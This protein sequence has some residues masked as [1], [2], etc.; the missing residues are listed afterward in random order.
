MES[1]S[2]NP[3]SLAKFVFANTA[4]KGRQKQEYSRL[5]KLQ[6]KLAHERNVEVDRWFHSFQKE[7][8]NWANESIGECSNWKPIFEDQAGEYRESYEASRLRLLGGD[9]HPEG[10]SFQCKPD[11]VME[12]ENSD[13]LVIERKWSRKEDRLI[14]EW[15]WENN[16]TQA[17][18]YRWIDEWGDLEDEKVFLVLEYY[19][20]E[21]YCKENEVF[22]PRL[23]RRV[24]LSEYFRPLDKISRDWLKEF[25]GYFEHF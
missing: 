21:Y 5:T 7:T 20:T 11:L 2:A 12:S 19:D 16:R 3:S 22:K 13:I 23:V 10:E 1:R 15:G 4:G 9:S 17:W 14:P 24:S 18:C 6:A 8:V 25:G